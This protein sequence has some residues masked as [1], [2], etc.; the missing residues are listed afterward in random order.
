MKRFVTFLTLFN[1][2][3]LA[4][5]GEV[6]LKCKGT[7]KVQRNDCGFCTYKKLDARVTRNHVVENTISMIVIDDGALKADGDWFKAYIDPNN[8]FSAAKN[9]IR[10]YKS[11]TKLVFSSRPKKDYQHVMFTSNKYIEIDR[12]SLNIHATE[13]VD[14]FTEVDKNKRFTHKEFNGKCVKQAAIF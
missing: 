10:S 7:F 5:A 11:G 3:T 6:S 12:Y 2:A 4:L 8:Q 13:R 14:H 9:N 1:L